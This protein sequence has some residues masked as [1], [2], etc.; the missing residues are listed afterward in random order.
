MLNKKSI[1]L[2]L[3]LCS[4]LAPFAAAQAQFTVRVTQ[5]QVGTTLEN[6]GTINMAADALR[7]ATIASVSVTNRGP[8]AVTFNRAVFAG[9]N[10]FT[11]VGLPDETSVTLLAGQSFSFTARYTPRAASHDRSPATSPFR[12]P[13]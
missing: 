6:G 12:R 4:A 10:D 7:V 8:G 9:S 3:F 5:G 13:K 1:L 11:F 2:A